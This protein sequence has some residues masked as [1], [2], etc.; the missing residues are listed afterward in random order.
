MTSAGHHRAILRST[1][2]RTTWMSEWCP[3]DEYLCRATARGRSRATP[4]RKHR[5][6]AAKDYSR[7]DER[8]ECGQAARQWRC[9]AAT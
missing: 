2:Y 1:Y 9:Q 5:A 7:V 3:I 8:P 6:T 4:S